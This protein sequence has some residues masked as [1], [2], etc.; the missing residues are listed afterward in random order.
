MLYEHGAKLDLCCNIPQ[1]A[2]ALIREA[3]CFASGLLPK[4]LGLEHG[5]C[6][7]ENHE[8]CHS[9]KLQHFLIVRDEAEQ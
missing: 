5:C 3:E 6:G 8:Y 4:G 7:L 1:V 9:Q 2:K